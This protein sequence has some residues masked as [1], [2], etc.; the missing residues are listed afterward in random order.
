MRGQRPK[1]GNYMSMEPRQNKDPESEY[2][3]SPRQEKWS[4]EMIEQSFH[5]EFNASNNEAEY[6]S[7][8]AGLWL[9][10]SIGAWEI[11]PFSD[12]KLVTSQFHEEY[13]E[14]NERMEAYLAVLWEIA[15]QFD[16][17]ELKKNTKRGQY[18]SQCAWH[19]TS[20]KLR[21]CRRVH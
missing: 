10:R 12:S 13:E 6:E 8:I 15:Q 2:S 14:K 18:V 20:W 17:F 4:G 11:S 21:R 9:A 7:L 16:K 1:N 3:S 5:L 19:P